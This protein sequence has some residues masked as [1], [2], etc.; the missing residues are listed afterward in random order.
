MITR[1]DL[2][3]QG[4]IGAGLVGLP[5]VA[6]AAAPQGLDAILLDTRFGGDLPA[7]F[8]DVPILRFAGDVTSVWYDQLDQ[9]WRQPGHVLGGITGSDALFVLEVLAV[10]HGR[11][12]ISRTPVGQR[13]ADGIAPISWVI[14]PHHP[15]V[16]A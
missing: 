6:L 11:R 8:A 1:R 5:Q 13:R 12:V 7:G 9:R 10:Q 15:S 4:A 16:V 3:K 14:A 2:I